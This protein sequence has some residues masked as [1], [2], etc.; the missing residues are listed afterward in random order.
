MSS[1][2]PAPEGCLWVCSACS[3]YS[4][5]RYGDDEAI[6]HGYDVSCFLNAVLVSKDRLVFNE[7]GRI[8]EIKPD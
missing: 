2:T 1:S 6:R 7:R 4:T 3:K 5:T 8:I